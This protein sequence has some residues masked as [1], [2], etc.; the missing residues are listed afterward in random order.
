MT[1]EQKDKRLQ[2]YIKPALAGIH[3]LRIYQK[4]SVHLLRIKTINIIQTTHHL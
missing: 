2:I 4:E 1:P 3:I